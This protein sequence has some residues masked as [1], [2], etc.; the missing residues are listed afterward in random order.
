M[1]KY[2]TFLQKNDSRSK[3]PKDLFFTKR[4]LKCTVI[5]NNYMLDKKAKKRT[6]V[7]PKLN[8]VFGICINFI[9]Y[10]NFF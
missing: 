5:I 8:E 10:S 1:I 7:H 9:P 6:F 4:G 2:G 3:Y